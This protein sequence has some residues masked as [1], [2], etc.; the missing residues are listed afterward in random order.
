MQASKKLIAS[1]AK[2]RDWKD[3]NT[4][5]GLTGKKPSTISRI[6]SGKQETTSDVLLIIKAFYK[7]RK[8]KVAIIEDQN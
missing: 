4:L 5:A 7:E 3:V 1:W 6:L 8:A 2:L